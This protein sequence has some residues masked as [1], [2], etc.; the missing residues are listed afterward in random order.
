[1]IPLTFCKFNHKFITAAFLSQMFIA[2][3]LLNKYKG[4]KIIFFYH[5]ATEF[6]G[7]EKA[8]LFS[9]FPPMFFVLY[10]FTK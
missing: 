5:S 1:M 9:I 3:I 7:E 8:S 10:L 6:Q 4:R 2:F